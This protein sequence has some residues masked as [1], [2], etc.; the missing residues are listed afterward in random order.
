M[1]TR[2]TSGRFFTTSALL[3]DEGDQADT[4]S[5]NVLATNNTYW[6]NTS[7]LSKAQKTDKYL[8]T[9]LV[10][11]HPSPT[12]IPVK[13]AFALDAYKETVSGSPVAVVVVGAYRHHL[14][15][16]QSTVPILREITQTSGNGAFVNVF[17]GGESGSQKMYGFTNLSFTDINNSGFGVTLQLLNNQAASASTVDIFVDAVRLVVKYQLNVGIDTMQVATTFNAVTL[18]KAYHAT[19]TSAVT[20]SMTTA[21]S[22]SIAVGG[23]SAVNGTATI[24]TSITSSVG[25]TSAVSGT[26]TVASTANTPQKLSE[27]VVSSTLTPAGTGS[28]QGQAVA[29]MLATATTAGTGQKA[30]SKT[31]VVLG[32][33]TI[34]TS[35]TP[36]LGYN[37]NQINATAVFSKVLT[38][39]ATFQKVLTA[40]GTL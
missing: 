19:G 6:T 18:A 29:E 8:Y 15:G 27:S 25:G 39:N 36:V 21:G 23:T 34:T 38:T 28:K 40:T 11:K 22:G 14:G 35:A 10:V 37:T 16:V 33:A 20:A 5:A 30:T 2:N 12:D 32:T 1:S 17:T 3:V 24:A 13:L 4:G 9:D 31:S 26:A 7:P